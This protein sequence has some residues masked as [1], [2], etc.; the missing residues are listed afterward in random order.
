L[1]RYISAWGDL[2]SKHGVKVDEAPVR[3]VSNRA[4]RVVG[5]CR[6]NQV[7]P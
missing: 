7:D 5:L 1:C 2:A 3:A 4:A 6:L